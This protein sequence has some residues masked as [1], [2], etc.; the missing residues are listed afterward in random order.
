MSAAQTFRLYIEAIT[1]IRQDRHT[2]LTADHAKAIVAVCDE[3]Q[4]KLER[5]GIE[6]LHLRQSAEIE[7]L[8][9]EF[10]ADAIRDGM[11]LDEVFDIFPPKRRVVVQ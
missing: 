4:A 6:I 2:A 9:R 1:L 11:G 5:Q 10:T 3:A 8:G 7:R